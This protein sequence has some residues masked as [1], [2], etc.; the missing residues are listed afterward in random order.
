MR[1]RTVIMALAAVLL[2]DAS[3]LQGESKSPTWNQFRGPNGSGVGQNCQPPVAIDAGKAVWQAAIP[4]GH[5]SPVL[6]KQLVVITAVE[7][8]R[9]VTLAFNID[10][11]ELAWR[12]EAPNVPLERVHD[13]SSPAASTPY[14]D[15]ERVYVYFGSYG[16]LCYDHQGR[17]VWDLAIPTP[18]SLY[19]MSSSPIVYGDLLILVVDNDANLPDSKLSQSK[20]I[21][22]NKVTGEAVW[23]TLRPFHRSGWSTPTIWSHEHGDEL[24][25][26]GSGRL[27]GYDAKTGVE[28]WFVNGFSRETVSRPITD[29]SRVYASASMIGG[30]AD[31]Q[32]DPEPYWKAVMRFD[33]NEDNRLERDEMTGQFTFPFRPELPAGHPGYGLPLPKDERRRKLRLDAMFAW[34]DKNKDGFWTK[35]EFLSNISFNRGKPNLLAIRPGGQ[36][37]V[38]TSHV[39]WAVHRNIPEVP[40]PV[41]HKDRIYLVRDGGVLAAVDATNGRFVYRKRLR[42]GGHY[43]AS[44]VIADDHLYVISEQGV[45]SVLKTG[46]DFELVHQ[47]D[48]QERVSATPAIDASTVYIRT[49]TQLLAFRSD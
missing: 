12:R 32:P 42:A 40:S 4:L 14:I 29:A 10:T 44:P 26:L 35:E 13:A 39:T 46:D 38:S 8:D 30:V 7:S 19:G 48:F 49:A 21:A 23:E 41:L 36:G 43:R 16:L 24:V 15:D 18:K 3:P 27:C 22:L 25:V 20:I 1:C 47:H 33:A 11:G 45:L 2:L 28:K 5:S 37:D 17:D 9:L 34:T 6:S 31:E